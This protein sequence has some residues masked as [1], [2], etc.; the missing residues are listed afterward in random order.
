MTR[1]V[2]APRLAASAGSLPVI[3][4]MRDGSGS[5]A[6]VVEPNCSGIAQDGY[7]RFG[8]RLCRWREG[9]NVNSW[10]VIP[11]RSEGPD[12]ESRDSGFD[13]SHRPGMTIATTTGAPS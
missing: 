11:G 12:P 8:M 7:G 2:A 13:A 6:D 5:I 1:E 3:P 9:Y 10:L 4:C